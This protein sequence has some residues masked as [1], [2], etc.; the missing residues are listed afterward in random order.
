MT[1]KKVK[2]DENTIKS[3]LTKGEKWMLFFTLVIAIFTLVIAIGT[4]WTAYE[5]RKLVEYTINPDVYFDVGSNILPQRIVE[6]RLYINY[7]KFTEISR[8][9][10]D[11]TNIGITPV[12]ILDI[13]VSGSCLYYKDNT[14]LSLMTFGTNPVIETG[15]NITYET[16]SLMDYLAKTGPPCELKFTLIFDRGKK[17]DVIILE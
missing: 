11:V 12:K 15:K 10:I 3:S 16:F 5:T 2:P 6:D 4:I 13:Y 7:S 14:I 1:A 8:V 17:Y 9:R